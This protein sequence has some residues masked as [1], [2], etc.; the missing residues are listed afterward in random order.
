MKNSKCS[1]LL[2]MNE[3]TEECIVFVL[4]FSWFLLPADGNNSLA[5][6]VSSSHNEGSSLRT[7]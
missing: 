7:T 3:W 4:T 1:L 6:S 5:D 2:F